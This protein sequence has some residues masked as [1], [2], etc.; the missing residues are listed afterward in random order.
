[1]VANPAHAQSGSPLSGKENWLCGQ[2]QYLHKYLQVVLNNTS[3]T[4]LLKP[5]Y[6]KIKYRKCYSGTSLQGSWGPLSLVEYKGQVGMGPLSLVES[7]RGKLG[8]VLCPL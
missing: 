8:W 4:I 6:I 7:T 2:N 1:M 3:S 5:V